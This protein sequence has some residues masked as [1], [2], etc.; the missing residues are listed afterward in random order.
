MA[1]ESSME[2][3]A[4][5]DRVL[6]SFNSKN[7]NLFNSSFGGEVVIV[8]GFAPFRWI[9]PNAQERWWTEAERWGEELGVASEHLSVEKMLHCQ[10]VGTRAYAVLSA[11]LTIGLKKGEWIIRPGI[12]IYTLIKVGGEWKA[13]SQTWGRLN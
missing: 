6:S 11:T 9:G 5:I 3:K 1:E 7:A 8:D 12:L 10:V 4:V 2:I 13:E